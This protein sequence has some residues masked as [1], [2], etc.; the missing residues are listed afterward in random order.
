MRNTHRTLLTAAA[1]VTGFKINQSNGAALTTPWCW[2]AI[3][4]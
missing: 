2:I 1:L 4:S 3:G